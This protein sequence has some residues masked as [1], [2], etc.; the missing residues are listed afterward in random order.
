DLAHLEGGT[1]AALMCCEDAADTN[2]QALHRK[3]AAIFGDPLAVAGQDI[4]VFVKCG[5]AP[6]ADTH[7]AE[8]LLQ[9]AEA[10]L[11][12]AK[13]T[14]ARH[15]RHCPEMNAEM[16]QRLALEHRLRR[17]LDLNQFR[18]H[19]QPLVERGTGHIIGAEALLR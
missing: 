5:L 2:L 7:D 1:F 12:K 9:N 14:G 10:A 3:I 18:L 6:L 4:P 16:A 15:L 13:T 8:S 19:Y 11:H 17:A